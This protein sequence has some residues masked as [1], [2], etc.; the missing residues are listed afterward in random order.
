MI[1]LNKLIENASL[2]CEI[3]TELENYFE[4]LDQYKDFLKMQAKFYPQGIEFNTFFDNVQTFALANVMN[5]LNEKIGQ[6]KI[7][8]IQ[9]DDGTEFYKLKWLSHDRQVKLH[10]H[11]R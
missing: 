5:S 7:E 8:A 9:T 3:Y 4:D 6:G 2:D 10:A 11:R 1:N